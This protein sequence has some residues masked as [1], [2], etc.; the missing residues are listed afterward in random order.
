MGHL[1]SLLLS[2]PHFLSYLK[3]STSK[4]SPPK[5]HLILPNVK[6]VR[7]SAAA[8]PPSVSLCHLQEYMNDKHSTDILLGSIS[9][10]TYS[11]S[12]ILHQYPHTQP[13][14]QLPSV[15]THTAVHRACTRDLQPVMSYPHNV[16]PHT[17]KHGHTQKRYLC[18]FSS[19]SLSYPPF[20][21]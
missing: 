13:C 19:L 5:W 14:P 15:P 9:I 20:R 4:N 1:Q 18:L 21:T 12:Q 2:S 3:P 7:Y 8:A 6:A 17:L 11:H 16:P 10:H